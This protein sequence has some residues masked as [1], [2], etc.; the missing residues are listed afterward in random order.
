ME[1]PQTGS[2][3]KPKL[4]AIII[5]IVVTAALVGGGVYYWQT[6]LQES[7]EIDELQDDK[8]SEDQIKPV[9]QPERDEDKTPKEFSY[10]YDKNDT[11]LVIKKA[12]FRY[13][14][15]DLEALA[16][17]CGV[18][19]GAEYYKDLQ[20]KFKNTQ[21]IVHEFKY[22]ELSQNPKEYVITL[23]P[24]LPMYEN[25]GEFQEDFNQC[26][27]GGDAYPRMLSEDWL[28]FESSCGSGFDDGSDMPIGCTK[29]KEFVATSL[30][31]ENEIEAELRIIDSVPRRKTVKEGYKY[32]DSQYETIMNA[33][34]D[35]TNEIVESFTFPESYDDPNLVF[36]STSSNTSLAS[37][38]NKIYSYD[39][40]TKKVTEV[41]SENEASLLRTV[42]IEGTKLILMRDGIDN[43]PGPC[44]SYWANWEG[45]EY[46]DTENPTSGLKSYTVP[47]YQ[48]EKGKVEQEECEA[49]MFQ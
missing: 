43:S 6:S 26:F 23:L 48:V 9:V 4:L 27:A 28:V 25:I 24:N 13:S 36:V 21:E 32:D 8:A 31:L 16:Q 11:D 7:Q 10:K 30:S 12:D 40:N 22:K 49:N 5:A 38:T 1:Q 19:K 18:D 29:V 41:Y 37:S 14:S 35:E 3:Q 46:L 42:G 17:E 33:I 2:Q 47:T 20:D 45:F 15:S 34:S 44:F 39:L